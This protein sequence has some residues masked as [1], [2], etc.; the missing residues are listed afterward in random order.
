MALRAGIIMA[1]RTVDKGAFIQQLMLRIVHE[2]HER[3]EKIEGRL[4]PCLQ[5]VLA[6]GFT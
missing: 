1:F 6:M 5:C 2:K 3:H 4:F